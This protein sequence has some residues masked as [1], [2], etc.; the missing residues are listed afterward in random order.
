MQRPQVAVR[1]FEAKSGHQ[2]TAGSSHGRGPNKN[3]PVSASVSVGLHVCSLWKARCPFGLLLPCEECGCKPP[4]R[5]LRGL[6]RSHALNKERLLT[7]LTR[8]VRTPTSWRVS[9]F[10]AAV[11]VF[12]TLADASLDDI[13]ESEPCHAFE[14][15]E[16]YWMVRYGECR[17]HPQKRFTTTPV[18][19]KRLDQAT[20]TF[21]ADSHKYI[22]EN[23]NVLCSWM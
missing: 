21:K 14:E 5:D 6:H 13:L 20:P 19:P 22:E 11:N 10:G 18:A 7:I 1:Q 15:Q 4:C 12:L 9:A 3:L 17:R 23:H 8:S 16:E 2:T